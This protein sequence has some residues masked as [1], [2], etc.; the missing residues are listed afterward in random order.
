M[1]N[2]RTNLEYLMSLCNIRGVEIARR[3]HIDQSLVGK[4]KNGTRTLSPA[5]SYIDG[6]A[7]MFYEHGKDK[8]EALFSDIYGERYSSAE[9]I[10]FIKAFLCS[11]DPEIMA[12]TALFKALDADA[13]ALYYSYE[14][15]SGRKKAMDYLI[16]CAEN[17]ESAVT[18]YLYDSMCF[19]WLISDSEYLKG[20]GRRIVRLLAEG[21]DIYLIIDSE[22]DSEKAARLLSNLYLFSTNRRFNVYYTHSV[23]FP[24]TYIIGGML[25][26]V[27][28]NDFREDSFLT[29]VFTDHSAVRQQE[30]YIRQLLKK[31]KKGSIR[32]Y[33]IDECFYNVKNLSVIDN[34]IYMFSPIPTI[35][36]MPGYLLD[37][38]LSYNDDISGDMKERLRE[39]NK[40]SSAEIFG[41]P[42]KKVRCLFMLEAICR[43]V[44]KEYVVYRDSMLSGTPLYVKS[45]DFKE[46]LMYLAQKMGADENYSIG[47]APRTELYGTSYSKLGY[48]ACK[49][50]CWALMSNE[51]SGQK[52]LFFM[53]SELVELIFRAQEYTWQNVPQPYTDRQNTIKMLEKA[54]GKGM[55]A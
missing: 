3:L 37:R 22:T 50:N 52:A 30:L 7:D 11:T 41:G 19:D 44:E 17:S 38:A 12:K 28:Y 21:S 55:K 9:T 14:G 47:M 33:Q 27:G 54:A 15:L 18:I 29:Q 4:W 46:H 36:S 35:F 1:K 45:A 20:L 6:L 51:H 53:N 16:S 8:L 32:R 40:L 24:T 13:S 48:L 43:A 39:Y 5:S 49:R 34:D 26:A 25:A 23:N 42:G 10:E 31:R 2:R